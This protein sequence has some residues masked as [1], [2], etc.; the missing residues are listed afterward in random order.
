M[1]LR[2]RLLNIVALSAIWFIPIRGEYAVVG[3]WPSSMINISYLTR[4][5]TRTKE[6]KWHASRWVLNPKAK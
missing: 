4:L 1:Q 6:F 2:S 5:E 3:K